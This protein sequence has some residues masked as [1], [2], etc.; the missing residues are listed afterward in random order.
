[1]LHSYTHDDDDDGI[2]CVS[3][4]YRIMYIAQNFNI[5]SKYQPT[6]QPTLTS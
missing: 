1:M 3:I 5:Y 2:M 6:K 4:M